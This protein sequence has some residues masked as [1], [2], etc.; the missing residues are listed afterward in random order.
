[1]KYFHL[2]TG[3]NDTPEEKDPPEGKELTNPSVPL[4]KVIPSSAIVICN[5]EVTGCRNK[6]NGL[7]LQNVI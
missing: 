1:M 3:N 5:A 2:I 6:Q 4:M 7:L